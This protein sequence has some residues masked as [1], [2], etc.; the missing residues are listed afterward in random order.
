MVPRFV[1]FPFALI[2]VVSAEIA[3]TGDSSS[4]SA[5]VPQV[6][7]GEMVDSRDGAKYPTVTVGGQ[8]W[9]ARNLAYKAD[10][11]WC[12]ARD[13]SYCSRYGRL[14]TW[15]A[16]KTVCPVGWH[17]PTDA[18]WETLA[19]S[20][21]G[22]DGG[23][24]RLKSTSGWDVNGNGSDSI[25]FGA[26]PGGNRLRDGSFVNVGSYA[27]FWTATESVGG[28]AYGRFLFCRIAAV[29][30]NGSHESSA[31]SVRCVKDR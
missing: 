25:G 11:S 28:T 22:V 30:P 19:L 10:S 17:L 7:R 27:N 29:P 1:L 15:A 14:Y 5:A 20:V 13:S 3:G 31:F 16:A 4:R 8:T 21:G 24:Y 2:C 23:G 6:S 26:L 12:Y 18:E 9:T